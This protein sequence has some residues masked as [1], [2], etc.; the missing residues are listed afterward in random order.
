MDLLTLDWII[1]IVL[2]SIV[3]LLSIWFHEYA[4]A[5]VSSI[6]WD[7]TPKMQWRLTPNPIK[8]IDP[9][10]FLMIFLIHFGWWKP[11][12]VDPTYYKNPLKDELLVSLA[13][14]FS[15]FLMAFV[16]TFMFVALVKFWQSNY[17]MNQFF[18]LF[19]FINIALWIFNLLPIYPLDGY[20]IIKYLKPSWAYFMEQNALM[21]TII[22]LA[23]VFLPWNPV[24]QIIMSVITPIYDLFMFIAQSLIF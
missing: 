12:Q 10:W 21:F 1:Q 17:L 7:P 24:W 22:M 13:W 9:I 3:F 14:P 19:I 8:H 23:I 6:L 2:L 16:W 5:Y 11:V 18:Q 15:N 20:R 4:H